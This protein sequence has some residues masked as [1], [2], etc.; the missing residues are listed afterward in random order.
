MSRRTVESPGDHAADEHIFPTGLEELRALKRPVNERAACNAL[1]EKILGPHQEQAHAKA[2]PLK[3]KHENVRGR[4]LRTW[5]FAKPM[6]LDV[7][8][9]ICFDSVKDEFRE[10]HA[11]G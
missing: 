9:A 3:V 5:Y 11:E 6:A 2:S 8:C 4:E 7:E 1:R 10:R